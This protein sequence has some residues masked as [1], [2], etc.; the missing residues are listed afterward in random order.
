MHTH[1]HTRTHT[2]TQKK[3]IHMLKKKKD[4]QIKINKK[5]VPSSLPKKKKHATPRMEIPMATV[6]FM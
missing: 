1:T 4:K 6:I 5:A 3:E 2:H